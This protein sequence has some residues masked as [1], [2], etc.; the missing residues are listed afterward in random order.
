M[1]TQR[2][3]LFMNGGSQAVRL[4]KNCRFPDDQR[5]VVVRRE[6]RAVILEPVDEWSPEVLAIFGSL[7]EEIERPDQQPIT[8]ARDPFADDQIHARHQHRQR[9]H[10]RSQ[11][12]RRRRQEP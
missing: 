3:K 8:E 1:T 4:P 5:E 9:P 10:A 6:G 11:T 7:T 12:R 2:A